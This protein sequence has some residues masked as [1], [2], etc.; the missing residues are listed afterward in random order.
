MTITTTMRGVGGL[1]T[2]HGMVPPR[3]SYPPNR[4][5]LLWTFAGALLLYGLLKIRKTNRRRQLAPALFV[6]MVLMAAVGI[7]GC[8][9]TPTGTPAG[10]STITVTATSGSLSHT[11]TV[12]L[13]VQ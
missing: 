3:I 5:I 1:P 9:N 7:A 2:A 6:G 8:T 12:M 4:F 13:T 10:T 11:T